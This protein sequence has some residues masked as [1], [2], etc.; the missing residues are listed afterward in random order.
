MYGNQKFFCAH[1]QPKL[2]MNTIHA[3][4]ILT[5]I[6]DTK[7]RDSIWRSIVDLGILNHLAFALHEYQQTRK[8]FPP[9]YGV[10]QE[11]VRFLVYIVCS[12][13]DEEKRISKSEI[14]HSWVCFIYSN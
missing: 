7:D 4:G 9:H 13:I 2:V 8:Y 5:S 6:V 12:E 1:L 3:I 14:F 11:I 10:V